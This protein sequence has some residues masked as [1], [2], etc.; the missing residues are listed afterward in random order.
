MNNYPRAGNAA[1]TNADD[2]RSNRYPGQEVERG[3]I[4]IALQRLRDEIVQLNEEISMLSERLAPMSAGRPVATSVLGN[5]EE[6]QSP[7]SKHAEELREL[8]GM[9]HSCRT[10]INVISA[11]LDI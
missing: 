9:V 5:G 11:Q 8:Q 10:R 7:A 1:M 3:A 2:M 4:T 6:K